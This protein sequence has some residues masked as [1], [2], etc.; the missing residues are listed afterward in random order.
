MNLPTNWKRT[1]ATLAVALGTL[2]PWGT[3][4]DAHGR[5]RTLRGGLTTVQVECASLC[6]EGSLT[7]GL[8]GKLEFTMASITPTDVPD[9]ST[10]EGVNT[11]TTPQG[12]LSGPDFGIW[13][14]ATGEF[15]DTM[16]FTSGTGAYAGARGT[17]VIIGVF[18][19]VTG[20]GSSRYTAV[21]LR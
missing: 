8:A 18:D 14:L 20:A 4:A 7:G 12:T 13:N 11:I 5:V 16:R 6:T 21:L 3:D 10:Y 15:V 1:T 9:V 19:P 2:I 17:M